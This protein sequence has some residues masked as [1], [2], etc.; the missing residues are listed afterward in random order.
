MASLTLNYDFTLLALTRLAF[1][2][3]CCGFADSRCA[4]NPLKKCKK[5]IN[6]ADELSF[7]AAAAMIMCYYK[8]ADD[9]ADSS[10]LKGLAK[11]ILKPYFALK[12]RKAMKKYPALD[13]IISAAM[14][15]QSETEKRNEAGIDSAAD[16]SARAMGEILCLG[17]EGETKEKLNRFGYLVGRW[18]YLADALDD[19]EDD[20]KNSSYNVF[21]N[22][23]K[24]EK[25]ARAYAAGAINLTAGQLVR[26]FEEMKPLRFSEIM[27]NIVYDGLHNSMNEVMRKKEEK[28]NERSVFCARL[29][30]RRKR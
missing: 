2:E 1:A 9:I 25:E 27:E 18:V 4:Y 19:M 7:S 8:A 29:A 21:N 11:R 28:K 13:G 23:N 17:F 26:L 14:Q 3:E 5:C 20:K 10:S 6:G 22:I 12:R 16:P 30:F 24:D 15:K